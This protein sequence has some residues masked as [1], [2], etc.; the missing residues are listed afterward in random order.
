MREHDLKIKFIKEQTSGQVKQREERMHK[1]KTK[2]G[3]RRQDQC[4]CG[5]GGECKR[6]EKPRAVGGG[7]DEIF[8]LQV[9]MDPSLL[10]LI[11]NRENLYSIP[12][13]NP[14]ICIFL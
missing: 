8:F 5:G 7:Q 9:F 13:P 4:I 10:L 3:K 11:K 6:G 12:P 14:M 2:Q 1:K